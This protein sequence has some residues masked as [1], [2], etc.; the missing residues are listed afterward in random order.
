MATAQKERARPCHWRGRVLRPRPGPG[1]APGAVEVRWPPL[2]PARLG[3][4]ALAG[5]AA[6]PDAVFL[7]GAATVGCGSSRTPF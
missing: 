4:G 7:Q 6:S 2:R 5:R 1:D 3:R